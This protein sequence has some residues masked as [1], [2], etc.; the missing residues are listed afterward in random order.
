VTLFKGGKLHS[1]PNGRHS[2]P[3]TLK[4]HGNRCQDTNAELS[5]EHLASY[6]QMKSSATALSMLSCPINTSL[7]SGR[8]PTLAFSVAIPRKLRL[9][10]RALV[11]AVTW[12]EARFLEFCARL[13]FSLLFDHI[14]THIRSCK[15]SPM[16]VLSVIS[17]LRTPLRLHHT[18]RCSKFPRLTHTTY[19]A[20][21]DVSQ[22]RKRKLNIPPVTVDGS[23]LTLS[24]M[25]TKTGSHR[26]PTTPSHEKQG[27]QTSRH[28]ATTRRPAFNA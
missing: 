4:I 1:H 10:A 14:L 9:L 20:I 11:A 22:L 13:R 15:M 6:L 12:Q 18:C 26:N 16:A 7:F 28:T 8:R 23:K 24:G 27:A 3:N 17:S 2:V 21:F 19:S 25:A 5:L